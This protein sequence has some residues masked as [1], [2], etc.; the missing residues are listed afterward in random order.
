MTSSALPAWQLSACELS[1]AFASGELSP[2]SVLEQT[3]TRMEA[4][5]PHIHALVVHDTTAA[6]TAAEA[7]SARWRQGLALSPLD[8]VVLTV[9]DNIPVRG[10]PC[11]WGSRL[12]EGFMPTADE[13]PV[14]RLR[15][16]GAVILGKTNVPEFTLQG[17]TDNLLNGATFNP[18]NLALTPGGSSGGAVAAVA[19]GIGPV[20]LATDGGGSIRRPASHTGLVGFKPGW[21]VVERSAGLPEILPEMEVIGPIARTVGDLVLVMQVISGDAKRDG[22]AARMTHS[23]WPVGPATQ[24]LKL[25]YWRHI[26]GGPV[27]AEIIAST[28]AVADALRALGHTVDVQDAP[29]SIGEFNRLAWPVLSATGL[30][31]MV[32]N[33]SRDASAFGGGA[34]A[35]D[36]DVTAAMTPAMQGLL[37][38]G[39]ALSATDLFAAQARVRAM[40]AEMGLLFARY[41]VVLT[42]SAAAL[43]WPA[44]ESHPGVIAGQPV[45]GR[46]HA[47]FTAFANACGLP[48]LALPANPSATGLPIGVQLVGNK[49][50]DAALLALGL[51]YE[52]HQ[53]WRARWPQI[54]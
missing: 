39:R 6:R 33:R 30:A 26:D 50:A 29:R 31:A 13:S 5:E 35:G 18:W 27:D 11:Q 34:T 2:S 24:P 28:D 9:K 23:A 12:Y 38:T 10:L 41:D 42:P 32:A 21:G 51:Q 14:A 40:R 43:P 25:A 47:V 52:S 16:A 53:L 4:V 17:Y 45:D 8:G 46:G 19:S 3:L 37:A 15:A 22:Q 36:A 20:A 49:C 54:G 48:A 44:R 1:A 7:S